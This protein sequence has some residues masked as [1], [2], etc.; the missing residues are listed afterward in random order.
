MNI[1]NKLTIKHLTMNKKRTI[2]TIV[3]VILSTALMVGIGLL[4]SSVR[5]NT[6]K[7]V[8]SNNGSQHLTIN[9]VSGSDISA[10]SKNIHVSSA[11]YYKSDGF[12]LA[13]SKNEYKPYYHIVSA[14]DSFLNE[15]NLKEG[16]LPKDETEVVISDHI[17][18]NGGIDLKV[19]DTINLEVGKRY[20]DDFEIVDND[21]YYNDDE[22]GHEELRDTVLKSYKVVGIVE[23]SFIEYFEAA[24]YSIFTKDNNI[25]NDSKYTM[26]ITFKNPKKSYQYGNSIATSLGFVNISSDK[27]PIYDELEFND[28]LLSLSG[29]SRFDNYMSSF[30]ATIIIVLCLISIGCIIVIYNSFAI[31]VMERKKQFGLFSSIGATKKQLRTTVFFEAFIIG[32]IGIPLGVLG[33][34]IGIGCVLALVNMLISNVFSFPL[35]LAVYPS[36]IIIPVIFMIITIIISA[37]LPAIRASRVTPIE[38]IRQNDDIKIKSKKIKTP[39]FIKYLFGVEGDL[40][41]KNIKR[42]KKKYRITILSLFISI[43]LFVSF[44]GIVYYGFTS[45]LEVLNVPEYNLMVNVNSKDRSDL[46]KK[47]NPIINQDGI[48]DYTVLNFSYYETNS[49]IKDM[50]D[51]KFKKLMNYESYDDL[52]LAIVSV[53]DKT[54]RALQNKAHVNSDT[55]FVLNKFKGT[56]YSDNNRKSYDI[57]KYSDIPSKI[58]LCEYKYDS[59]DGEGNKVCDSE[60]SNLKLID[61]S[62]MGTEELINDDYIVVIVNEDM[63]KSYIENDDYVYSTI[64]IKSHDYSK[65]DAYLE[66]YAQENDGIYYTNVDKSLKLYR[67]MIIVVK[68]LLYGFISL[69][70]LIGVTS[71]FNTIHTSINLR[72]KEF[73]M[74]RSMGLTPKGF[75]KILA[76]ESLFV[77]IKSL[78]YSIP[79][80]IFVVYLLYKSFGGIAVSDKFIIPW[81]SILIATVAVFII[82]FITMMYASSKIKHEN[83]LEAIREENI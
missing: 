76:F 66:N 68:I 63:F 4:F 8:I 33:G 39:K 61:A 42:N 60:I 9:S 52:G 2:V 1:L 35:V 56:I 22:E 36:F 44:S 32:I 27:M 46:S 77:G 20:I 48:D 54:Y 72:R 5:D 43:V 78:L 51:D 82:V 17:K 41:L 64:Y 24:G 40:A 34:F 26:L 67:N 79:V 53:D 47:V 37:Y 31:S 57:K 6:V 74:L 29:I 13:G 3:G 10:I 15:L 55:A 7:T 12:A 25:A 73:A 81:N 50:F 75:N 83:I 18:R 38:A 71:V 69:V 59:E 80:S 11:T 30:Y 14:S 19:G 21:H 58:S 49:F 23:R 28:S 45:T 16:R 70:T 65:L 62:V